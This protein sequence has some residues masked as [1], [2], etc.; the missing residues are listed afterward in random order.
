MN[1]PI[2]Y[3]NLFWTEFNEKRVKAESNGYGVD[4][5]DPEFNK[6][7]D[8]EEFRN[9]LASV[10]H[11]GKLKISD[12]RLECDATSNCYY[13]FVAN[14]MSRHRFEVLLRN[15][16]WTNTAKMT[17]TETNV[18]IKDDCFWRLK[19]FLV[20]MAESCKAQLYYFK[21]LMGMSKE[22]LSKVVILQYSIMTI[23]HTNGSSKYMPL[24]DAK[25]AYTTNFYLFRGM[26]KDVLMEFQLL[27]FQDLL[28]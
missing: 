25:T 7:M 14:L 21:I 6:P 20:R 26:D 9:F 28:L 10:L 22:F 16:L 27:L 17:A 24:D 19:E 3:L 15:L 23:S 4:S 5:K 2:D 18:R 1:D 11:F 12:R 8:L 13:L